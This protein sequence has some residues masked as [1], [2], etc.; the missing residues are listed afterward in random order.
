VFVIPVIAWIAAV[1]FAVVV[2]G[3][4]CYEVTWKARRLRRD[5]GRLQ[6]QGERADSLQ[7]DIAAVQD[8]LAR[9]SRD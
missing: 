9:A 1:V 8:R 4:C 6:V 3:F 7:R 2:L 5:I